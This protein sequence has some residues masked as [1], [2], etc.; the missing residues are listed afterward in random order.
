M[1]LSLFVFAC[2]LSQQASSTF[3]TINFDAGWRFALGHISDP[4][5]D[6]GFGRTG[7]GYL[8]KAGTGEG[9]V[10]PGFSDGRWRAVTLPHDWAIELP[11]DEKAEGG[12]GYKA[13]GRDYP[14]NS[15]GWYRKSF[16]IDKSLIGK[17]ISIHFDGIYRNASV[18]CNGTFIKRNESGYIGFDADLTN[19]LRYGGKNVVVVRVDASEFEGWFYEGAGIYRHTYL[20]VNDPASLVKDGQFLMPKVSGRYGNV[21]A[22]LEVQNLGDHDRKLRILL[23]LEDQQGR[24]LSTMGATAE[25]KPQ[26]KKIVSPRLTVTDPKLWSVEAPNLYVG[27]VELFDGQTKIDEYKTNIGFRTVVW[28]ANKG[29]TIN[30]KYVKIQGTCNHQDAA[31]VGVALPD[32]LNYWRIEQLKKM[33]C[34]A[35]RTSH[36]P[37]TP[38][39]LD[40]CDK[41]GMIVLDETRAFG[42]SEEAQSQLTRLI[43]RDRNHASVIFWS[44]GNEEFALNGT[45]E[46]E[47]MGRAA[48]ELA[49]RLDPTRLTTYAGNNGAEYHGINASVDIRGFNYGLTQADRYHKEH[50]TQPVHGSETASTTTTRGTYTDDYKNGR[51]NAYDG[52]KVSWGS[53]AEEWWSWAAQ[54]EWFA[55]GFVWTGFDYR[56]EPTP[57]VWPTI[58]SHFGIMDTCGFPKDIYYYY[59]AWWSN[60]P[61]LH[62]LPHW[63][64]PGD[65]GKEKNVWV[66]SNADEVELFLNGKSLGKQKMPYTGHLEWKVAYQ[67]GKLEAIGW[68]GGKEIG[69]ETVATTG[70]MASVKIVPDRDV[71]EGDGK[72]VSV[73][74]FYGLDGEGRTVPTADDKLEF[75]IEGPGKLIGVGNGDPTCLEPDTYLPENL[76]QDLS[77]GWRLKRDISL[78]DAKAIASKG[79]IAEDMEKAEIIENQGMKPNSTL[80]LLKEFQVDDPRTWKTLELGAI[81]DEGFI[82]LNGKLLRST[83]VWNETY[84]LPVENLLKKGNNVLGIVCHNNAGDGGVS[85]GAAL[86]GLTR[87]GN[88]SRSLFNG[89]AQAIVQST[90]P[91]KIILRVKCKGKSFER[92]ITAR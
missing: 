51:V 84:Q 35:Y 67:P 60:Q 71:I 26:E 22:N 13:I 18:W 82:Y 16:D 31:G 54:R 14:Q 30:G 41:L 73:V 50:P 64:W 85:Q 72:D 80:V 56:G 23:T 86:I 68:K 36:N 42:D 27:K 38:E 47:R 1:G 4:S 61:V 91:G 59:Q 87:A 77:A 66:Y 44:I 74:D 65:E 24:K 25:L 3:Q 55:G 20:N 79:S 9:P 33:G 48:T 92:V 89:C 46:G 40:A 19:L 15:I 17:R 81:D 90:G 37:P 58:N 34:N 78:E 53:G 11:F 10:N 57:T 43:R 76:G 49:H 52:R 83:K 88:W 5:K 29:L 7:M 32:R 28:D 21:D 2:A 12:H 70:D 45:D 63:N 75:E 69:R 6:F 62:I 8:A 39:L